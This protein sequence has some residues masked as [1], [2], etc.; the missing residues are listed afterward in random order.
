MTL[1]QPSGVGP[2]NDTPSGAAVETVIGLLRIGFSVLR[3]SAPS[4]I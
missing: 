1:T 2:D 4:R 3:P